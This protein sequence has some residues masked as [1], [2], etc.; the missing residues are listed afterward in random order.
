MVARINHNHKHTLHK[1]MIM[2]QHQDFRKK[3]TTYFQNQSTKI[4]IVRKVSKFA[5]YP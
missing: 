3:P 4:F 5:T 1:R 2:S